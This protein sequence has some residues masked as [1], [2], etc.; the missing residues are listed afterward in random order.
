MSNQVPKIDCLPG[1]DCGV[2][3]WDGELKAS[4]GLLRELVRKRLSGR[5][6]SAVDDIMQE[7]AIAA[8]TLPSGKVAPESAGAWLRQVAVNK[9]RDLWRKVERRD[10]LQC[11]FG[12]VD[13][14]APRSP[15]EWVMA[16]EETQL[17]DGA[18]DQLSPEERRLLE[19]KYLERLS[20]REISIEE[21]MKEKAVEY[22]LG[23]AR[24]TM[25]AL[26]KKMIESPELTKNE[27]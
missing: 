5:E 7:V 18:L 17:I 24:Q 6:E 15:Y 13:E 8:H 26:L 23:K 11:E 1:A 16:M 14:N 10:R 3:D 2:V 19:R 20:C 27:Q 21:G 22:R 9:V 4:D 12:Q 25:R